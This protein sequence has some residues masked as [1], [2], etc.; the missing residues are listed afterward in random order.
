MASLSETSTHPPPQSF[1]LGEWLV[2]PTLNLVSRGQTLVHV[3][4]KV[5]DVLVLLAA[6]PGEVVSKDAIITTVWSKRILADA[7]L[8]RAVFEL[9]EALGDDAQQ[10]K[11]IETVAKRG[12]RLLAPV[13]PPKPSERALRAHP[14]QARSPTRVSD[15]PEVILILTPRVLATR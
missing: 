13:G 6:H 7:V 2:E 5:M 1:L 10:P 14:L 15:G 9:R 12:Y 11:F 3:R 8:S 4:P